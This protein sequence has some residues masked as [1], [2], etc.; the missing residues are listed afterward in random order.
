MPSDLETVATILEMGERPKH[1]RVAMPQGK[2]ALLRLEPPTVPYYRWL[3]DRVGRDWHWVDRKRLDDETL[4][5]L[6]ADPGIEIYVL[7]VGGV[8]AGFF[9]L[10]ARAPRATEIEHLGLAPDFLG[11]RLGPF[12]LQAA[13]ERAWVRPIDVLRVETC[14]LDHPRALTLY[15]RFGF[16]PVRQEPRTVS[17]IVAVE[18]AG[19]A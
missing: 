15:Q 7:Y 9:E 8:P 2:V 17:P 18:L 3:Y 11:R 10:D 1:A 16:R 13:I 19:R 6:I 14:T 4:G 12:L 5:G